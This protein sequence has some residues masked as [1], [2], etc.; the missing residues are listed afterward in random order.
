MLKDCVLGI[1]S[2][3]GDDA[4]GWHLVERLRSHTPAIDTA[5]IRGDQ[6][7]EH[8]PGCRRLILVDA[9][10]AAGPPGTIVRFEWPD[11]RI[12]IEVSRSTHGFSVGESLTMADALGWL[13]ERVIV[14]GI[15]T[16][17]C[18]P[19]RGLSP[20]VQAALPAVEQHVLAE[21]AEPCVNRASGVTSFPTQRRIT[22]WVET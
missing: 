10:S 17:G 14:L 5:A 15:A 3:H 18:E 12:L 8:L 20:P 11:P 13:P 21:L 2:P 22:E 19:G 7:L 1:G 4:V 9:C 16:D 6:L